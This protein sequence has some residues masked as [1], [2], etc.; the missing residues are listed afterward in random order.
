VSIS[1]TQVADAGGWFLLLVTVGFFGWLYFVAPWTPEE[2]KKLY[3]I[4]VLFVASALFWSVFEQA[5]STL[6]LFADRNTRNVVAGFEYPSG[7]FQSMNAF[8]IFTIAP[9]FAWIWLKLGKAGKEPSSVAKFSLGLV[10]AGLGF[11]VLIPAAQLAAAGAR[12]S[13]LWLVTTYLLHT[14]GELSLSPVGLSAMTKLAPA[15]IAGLVMGVWFLATAIGNY[16]GGRVAGLYESLPLPD[17]F[18]AVAAFAVVAGLALAVFV[19]PMGRLLG[20]R[21]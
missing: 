4:G 9:V 20:E 1:A 16:A 3:L 8:F 14:V 5:G 10:C 15:R 17:L 18:T 12:V 19:K 6:N 11:A 7:W 13:P 2:R 21:H